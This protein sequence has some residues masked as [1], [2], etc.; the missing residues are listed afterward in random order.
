M[1]NL[2]QSAGSKIPIIEL[3]GNARKAYCMDCSKVISR[4]YINK[5][6]KKSEEIPA[7]SYCG[8]RIKTNVVLFN[9]PLAQDILK[10]ARSWAEK[11]FQPKISQ[12]SIYLELKVR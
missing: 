3:H 2:Q 8:G 4:K 6:L 9:E 7:C 1:D 5:S 11:C 12:F 10:T